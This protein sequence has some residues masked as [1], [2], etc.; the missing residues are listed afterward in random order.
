MAVAALMFFALA[1]AS[2]SLSRAPCASFRLAFLA[3]RFCFLNIK[4]GLDLRIKII[5]FIYLCYL[6]R[7]SCLGR[8]THSS[9]PRLLALRFP[10]LKIILIK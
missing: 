6:D 5:K 4:K 9:A 8:Q 7:H 3:D 1:L 10:L 2:F